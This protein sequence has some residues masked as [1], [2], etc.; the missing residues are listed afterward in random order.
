MV[1]KFVESLLKPAETRIA[2]NHGRGKN[3]LLLTDELCVY[4]VKNS[5]RSALS[6]GVKRLNSGPAVIFAHADV[7]GENKRRVIPSPHLR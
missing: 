2:E 7:R 3:A 4:K 1:L 6:P 5:H